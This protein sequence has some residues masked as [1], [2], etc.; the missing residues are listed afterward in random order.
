V[1]LYLR[2]CVVARNGGGV[3]AIVWHHRP[4]PHDHLDAAHAGGLPRHIHPH[5]PYALP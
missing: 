5:P 3:A 1:Y 4:Y 2:A